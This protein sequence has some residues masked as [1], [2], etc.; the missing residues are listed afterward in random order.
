M[1][2]LGHRVS[3]AILSLADG[4]TAVRHV[5]PYRHAD[6]KFHRRVTEEEQPQR[7]ELF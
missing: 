2:D 1:I 4:A 6:L 5:A 7:H 3:S